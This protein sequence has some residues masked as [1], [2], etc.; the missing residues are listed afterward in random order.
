MQALF[1]LRR[2]R[3]LRKQPRYDLTF[4]CPSRPAWL[5]KIPLWEQP[6]AQSQL[7]LPDRSHFPSF[8]QVLSEQSRSSQPRRRRRLRLS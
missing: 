1:H 2:S 7:K 8:L 5:P 4:G 6:L 3:D